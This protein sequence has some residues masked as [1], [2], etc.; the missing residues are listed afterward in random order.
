M[1]PRPGKA[2]HSLVLSSF[3]SGVS[4]DPVSL[5]ALSSP[6]TIWITPPAV[7]PT[8]SATSISTLMSYFFCA[9]PTRLVASQV[10]TLIFWVQVASPAVAGFMAT[11][12]VG[13]AAAVRLQPHQSL[14]DAQAAAALLLAAAKAA[15]PTA[16][17]P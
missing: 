16:I 6:G 3:L 8:F 14:A 7:N 15:P 2:F 13:S 9:R 10:E 11:S 17:K 5:P 12:G 4:F 1:V